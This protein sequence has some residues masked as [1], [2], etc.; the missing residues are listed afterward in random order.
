M[1]IVIASTIFLS[2]VSPYVMTLGLMFSYALWFKIWCR[3]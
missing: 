2:Y 1:L 3:C